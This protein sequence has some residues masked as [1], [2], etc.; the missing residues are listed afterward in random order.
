MI[1]IS[2]SQKLVTKK[3]IMEKIIKNSANIK[4]SIDSKNKSTF[5]FADR[6]I[7]VKIKVE[8][9]NKEVFFKKT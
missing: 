1:E 3:I 8:P 5:Y 7:Y 2:F 6:D 4:C 9:F